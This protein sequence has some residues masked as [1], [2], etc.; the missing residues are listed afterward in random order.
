MLHTDANPIKIGYHGIELNE[1]YAN[2]RNNIKQKNV[3]TVLTISQRQY[4]QQFSIQDS[5]LLSMSHG[6]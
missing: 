6:T 1:E 3:N 2:A 4:L 5:F